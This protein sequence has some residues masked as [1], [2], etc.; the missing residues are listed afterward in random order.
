M[1]DI[2]ERILYKGKWISLKETLYKAKNGEEVRW[3]SIERTNTSKTVVI[4]AKLIPSNR[5]VFIKQYRPAINNYILGFPA[6]LI[7]EESLEEEALRELKEETGYIGTIKNISPELYSNA[8][9]IS[10][11]V[12]LVNIQVD[13][14]LEGNKNP[15]QQLESEEEIEVILVSEKNIR[16]FLL[17]EQKNGT[18]LGIGPWYMFGGLNN[19]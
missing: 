12:R 8:A 6:G 18:A 10:D 14:N 15:V 13:E 5:Y 16:D 2:K 7:E 3:E 1:K 4:A 11:T 19:I 9:L 17:E